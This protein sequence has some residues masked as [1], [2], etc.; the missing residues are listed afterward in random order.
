MAAPFDRLLLA[1][2]VRAGR[3][4]W[5]FHARS[6]A[7]ERGFSAAEID[8]V[9]IRGDVIERY[10]DLRPFPAALLLGTAANRPVHVVAAVDGA[11]QMAYVVT[12][13]EPSSDR[14]EGDHRT[15]SRKR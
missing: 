15:R 8:E 13:Y 10:A 12:V 11:G 1:R 5:T 6:R 9:L 4:Q 14:F 7:A 3:A 2:L